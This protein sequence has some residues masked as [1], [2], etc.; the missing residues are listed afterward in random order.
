MSELSETIILSLNFF[1]P[2]LFS[3]LFRVY[4]LGY[5]SKPRAIIGLALFCAYNL[6]VP[7]MLIPLIGYKNYLKFVAFILIAGQCLVF[8]VSSDGFWKTAFLHS[9]QGNVVVALSIFC[10]SIR[11]FFNLSYLDL[12]FVLFGVCFAAYV[13]SLMFFVKPLKNLANAI[14]INWFIMVF[15]P[16]GTLFANILIIV[17]LSITFGGDSILNIFVVYLF[18]AILFIYL[19][20]LSKIL[21]KNDELARQAESQQILKISALAMEQQISLMKDSVQQMRVL[22]HDR[23]H[24]NNMIL[25]LLESKK[26]KHAVELLINDQERSLSPII[27]YCENSAVNAAVTYYANI[28]LKYGIDFKINLDIPSY[29]T[30][31]S[32]D[33]CMV[34]ANLIENAINACAKIPCQD[35][36]FINLKTVYTGQLIVEIENSMVGKVTFDERGYHVSQSEGHGIGTK[37]V[38]AFVTQYKGEIIYNA[39]NNV[40]KVRMLV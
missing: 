38:L 24:F 40:F 22:N 36:P 8:V 4:G 28:A 31:N 39:A 35:K 30:I 9:V 27:T 7:L 18:T 12:L 6:I 10:N 20:I 3:M 16:L 34:L 2:A 37:S 17:Y 15:I 25:E 14:K 33:I 1:I 26:Y 13:V 21:R 19:Y 5:K 32:I 11:Y 23:R 29:L